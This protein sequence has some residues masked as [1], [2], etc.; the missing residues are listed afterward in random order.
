MAT[1]QVWSIDD[2]DVDCKRNPIMYRYVG[3]K[4]RYS[5]TPWKKIPLNKRCVSCDDILPHEDIVLGHDM[6]ENCWGLSHL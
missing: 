5:T 2:I 1:T 6:C 3:R 4:V